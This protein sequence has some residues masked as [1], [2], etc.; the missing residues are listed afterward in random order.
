MSAENCIKK[1]LGTG[2]ALELDDIDTDRIL[3]ARFMKELS[4]SHLGDKAFHDLRKQAKADGMVHPFDDYLRLNA[5]VL[6]VA[7]NFGC[8][9]SREH[10]PQSLKRWGIE[11]EIGES[12]GEIFKGNCA[13]IGLP[14]LTVTES[15]AVSLRKYI[16]QNASAEIRVDIETRQV[17]FDN[18]FIDFDLGE[19]VR[20]RLLNGRWNILLELTQFENEVRNVYEKLPYAGARW[21]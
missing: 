9:S 12:F 1:I 2:I 21:N 19:A 10:A 18:K 11:V 13:S 17:A 15:D 14:C 5:K 3:P 4:F 16:Q 8:G 20:E 7:K 6:A